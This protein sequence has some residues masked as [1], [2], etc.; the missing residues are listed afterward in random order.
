VASST[1]STTSATRIGDYVTPRLIIG[2]V[3]VVAALLLVFQNTS[4]G[5]FH[6]L[7][8]DMKAPR[9]LWLLGV[10]AAGVVTGLL[11]ARRRAART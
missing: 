1:S 10:F 7:W 6:F 8:F 3:I 5:E 2:A 4:T 9:W 11:V